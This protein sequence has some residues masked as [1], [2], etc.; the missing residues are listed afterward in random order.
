M[1]QQNVELVRQGYEALNRGD[2]EWVLDHLAREFEYR[3]TQL[4]PDLLGTYRGR[5][6]F[7]RFWNTFR[8]AWESVVIEI[9]RL[10][11]VGDD[12]VLALL[13]FNGKGRQGVETKLRV[14]HLL[15]IENE[16]VSR[17][18]GFADWETALEAAGLRK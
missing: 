3:T 12:R 5:D 17:I 7:R 4:F 1:S 8:E 15:T 10:E 9:A 13:W 11:P 18:V 14:T 2:L 16:L 6:G